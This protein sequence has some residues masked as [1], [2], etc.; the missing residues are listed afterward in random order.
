MNTISLPASC[1]RAATKALYTDICEGLG[2]APLALDA[3]RV[4]KIGQAM[5]QVLIAANASDSGIVITQP[6]LAFCDAVKL[7]GLEPLLTE[8]SA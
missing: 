8:P 2:P 1:D 7:A 6:S 4:E 3:S 5:L